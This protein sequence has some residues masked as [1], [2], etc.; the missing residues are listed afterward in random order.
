MSGLALC[1][2][3]GT[4]VYDNLG[5]CSKLLSLLSDEAQKRILEPIARIVDDL[6]SDIRSRSSRVLVDG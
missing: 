5:L 4:T 6:V 3:H 2:F 1:L